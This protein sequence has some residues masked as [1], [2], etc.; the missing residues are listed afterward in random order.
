MDCRVIKGTV[1]SGAMHFWNIVQ[2]DG[3]YYNVDPGWEASN[4]QQGGNYRY[5]LQCDKTFT[6]HNRNSECATTAFYSAHPM[7]QTDYVPIE[8]FDIALSRMILGNALEFQFGIPQSAMKDWTGTYATIEKLCPDGTVVTKTIQSKYWGT[9]QVSGAPYWAISYNG[10][11]AKEMADRFYVTIYDGSGKA[12]SNVRSD[13]VRDYVGR[14]FSGQSAEGKTMMVDMLNYGA[15]AQQYCNYNTE[16]LANNSL[17]AAQLACGTAVSPTTANRLIYDGNYTGTRLIL[18]SRIQM[19][20]GFRN[21]DK[22]MYAVYTYVDHYGVRYTVRVDGSQF[23][24]LNSYLYAIELSRLVYAD[25]R[26]LVSVR[27][28][29]ADGTLYARASDSMESYIHRAG[30]SGLYEALMKFTDSAKQYLH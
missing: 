10:L 18:E 22:S 28:Y 29:K 20:L 4:V 15:A 24:K 7:G 27:V 8:K 9:V 23:I 5:R 30:A 16:D 12:V 26:E 25:A 3:L 14:A 19:Q 2:L 21:L 1:N 17:T 6:N 13:S 11:A